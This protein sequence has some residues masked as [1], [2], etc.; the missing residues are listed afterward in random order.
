MIRRINICAGPGTGKS[1]LA[2]KLYSSMKAKK[3]SVELAHEYVKGWAY[4]DR[5]INPFDQFYLTNKQLQQE[6]VP[7]MAGVDYVITDSPIFLPYCYA[8]LDFPKQ[9]ANAIIPIVDYFDAEFPALYLFLNRSTEYV[10]EGRFGDEERAR[11]IDIKIKECLV[12]R[13]KKFIDIDLDC[14]IL[15]LVEKNLRN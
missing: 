15:K 6:Y 9:V 13:K 7:L 1:T 10:K 11:A 5:K 4:L 3:Y 12:D 2:A 14:D 8:L